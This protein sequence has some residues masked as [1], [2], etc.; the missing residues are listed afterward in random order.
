MRT[1]T[2]RKSL[3]R[4]ERLD[5]RTM[6][7]TVG[8]P[9]PESTHLT[10]SF[11]PDATPIAGHTSNLF[12]TLDAQMPRAVWQNQ[13]L[14]AVQSWAAVTNIS[15]GIVADAGLAFGTPGLGQS[16]SRFG[17][18]RV[19]GQL[20]DEQVLSISVPHD[21]FIS[22]TWSG[23][24]LINSAF[25]FTTTQADL[26]S[27]MLH[28]FGHAFGL[29]HSSDPSSVMFSHA[30]QM[31]NGLAPSDVADIRALYGARQ[32]D[33][34]EGSNG[35]NTQNRATQIQFD[36]DSRPAAAFGDL[37]TL[38]D[39]DYYRID[40]PDDYSGPMT[41]RV[42]TAGISLLSPRITLTDRDGN[43]IA[44]AQSTNPAGASVNL[45]LPQVE[46]DGRYYLR[47]ERATA[48]NSG[49][50]RYGLAVTFDNLVSI[51]PSTIE[52][53][54][55]GPYENLSHSE[56]AKLFRPSRLL[57][58]PD[59]GADDTPAGASV[60][61]SSRGGEKITHFGMIASLEHSAD[62]D[63]YRIEVEFG[64]TQTNVLT[65]T[66]AGLLASTVP[67]RLVLL[68]ETLAPVAH[69][70]LANGNGTFTIQA[71]GVAEG[72]Y[73]LRVSNSSL[74]AAPG[75]Y[76]FSID[77]GGRVANLQTYA[78]GSLS[79]KR[80]TAQQTL[81]VAKPQLFQLLLSATGTG[82]SVGAPLSATIT[83]ESGAVVMTL[84]GRVGETVSGPAILLAPGPYS[85]RYSIQLPP[86]AL[87]VSFTLRGLQISDPIGPVR[88]DTTLTPRYV[89][90]A[91]PNQFLYP[92]GVASLEAFF[93][94]ILF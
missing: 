50:G 48:D 17:D 72:A 77:L 71:A 22:G 80:P 83:N 92:N 45:T 23:D 63:Y 73:Y 59:N 10:L 88:E 66:A 90:P 38:Q 8:V 58:N 32:P 81:Y 52:H 61:E 18:I 57:L 75:N 6:P 44:T 64:E 67:P 51:R 21:P 15:V 43:A 78:S 27:I 40:T 46:A 2:N 37:T 42:L 53:V 20:M 49:I 4:L 19:G 1:I 82:A 47:V 74:G 29:E 3:L 16:D 12:A 84:A 24:V 31:R 11:A 56:V 28:E 91:N 65:A 14:R 68:D 76:S 33:I 39:V 34:N 7:S 55:R 86:G 93:W 87:P 94:T 60:L 30:A 89:D 79:L 9:W 62:V 70:V 41:I 25:N 54:L 13:M 5:E 85:I 69:T 26:Y 35:N 36:D